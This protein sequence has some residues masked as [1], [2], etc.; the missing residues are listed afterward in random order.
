MAGHA[1]TCE[2]AA[3][4]RFNGMVTFLAL[5]RDLAAYHRGQPLG[6]IFEATMK[7]VHAIFGMT[8]LVVGILGLLCPI[9]MLWKA[10]W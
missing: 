4:S 2:W 10:S 5:C 9:V 6:Q 8:T 3:G 1:T 7:S